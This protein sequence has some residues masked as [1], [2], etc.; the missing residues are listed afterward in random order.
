[1]MGLLSSRARALADLL[2]QERIRQR[3]RE[4]KDEKSESL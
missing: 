3:R 2:E 4:D 1:M